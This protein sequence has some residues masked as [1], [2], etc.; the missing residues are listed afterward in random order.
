MG[1]GS[2]VQGCPS[3]GPRRGG[4][5]AGKHPS[6]TT[7]PHA[8]SQ[9]RGRHMLLNLTHLGQPTCQLMSYDSK[10]PRGTTRTVG[11][12][13]F[14]ANTLTL[15]S[16]SRAPGHKA[17]PGLAWVLQFLEKKCDT[18]IHLTCDSEGRVRI[19]ISNA[20]HSEAWLCF[21][22]ET[23]VCQKCSLYSRGQQTTACQP[24]P[25]CCCFCK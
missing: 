24:N 20:Q 10:D 13:G 16:N 1:W 18:K 25:A 6:C 7:Q 11:F 15:H 23:H 3:C 21:C 19:S 2:R 22:F 17:G 8:K 14:I 12:P 4:P 9:E 5:S